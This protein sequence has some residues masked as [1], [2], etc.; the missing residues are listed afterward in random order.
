M[1]N[2]REEIIQFAGRLSGIVTLREDLAVENHSKGTHAGTPPALILVSAGLLSKAGPY[3]LYASLA[4]RLATE[5]FLV[6]RFDLGGIG[7]SQSG[8]GSKPLRS[9][10]EEEIRAAID[11]LTERYGIERVSL[12]GLCSGAEDSFLYAESDKR[13]ERVVL[14]DPFSYRT[15]GW[16]LHHLL[17]RAARKVLRTLKIYEPVETKK[18]KNDVPGGGSLV[19]YKYIE[20]VESTRILGVLLERNVKS[21]FFYTGGV[22]ETFNHKGQLQKM[23]PTLE[24]R[25]R[26]TLDHLPHMDHTQVLEEDRQEMIERILARLADRPTR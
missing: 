15:A 13:V 24:F 4:R 5:G 2:V 20:A 11:F 26:V 17:H 22:R 16:E 14:I 21:H 6:L 7:E 8:P 12:G 18:R 3:R 19:A 25:D 9:R 23:F 10:T 1:L